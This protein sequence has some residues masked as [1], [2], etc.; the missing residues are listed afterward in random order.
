MVGPLA[1]GQARSCRV[2]V[3][4]PF[5]PFWLE[6]HLQHAMKAVGGAA[7]MIDPRARS[8]VMRGSV[9]QP[10]RAVS[11]LSPWTSLLLV[12]AFI[13]IGAHWLRR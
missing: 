9:S 7:E 2:E 13:G 12:L 5:L 10:P 3:A 1:A 4:A 8:L 11:T 6:L